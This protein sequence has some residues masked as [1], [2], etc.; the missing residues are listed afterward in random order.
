MEIPDKIFFKI[1]E[2]SDIAGV[3]PYVLRYWESEFSISPHKSGSGQRLYR[4]KDIERILLIK[5]LLYQEGFT[6]A[7]ARKHLSKL[8]RAGGG[9]DSDE[10]DEELDEALS[11]SG[12]TP[13]EN[14]EGAEAGNGLER[15]TESTAGE[16]AA[17]EATTA[18]K[19]QPEGF[20]GMAPPA[21]IRWMNAVRER[22]NTLNDL[23]QKV[24]ALKV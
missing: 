8:N 13:G 21:D 22:V 7:G 12:L 16:G 17:L 2:V 9:G 24:R 5:R 4:R 6:I 1:G 3:K 10:L 14:A 18:G 20:G 23:I 15:G 11:D 19:G